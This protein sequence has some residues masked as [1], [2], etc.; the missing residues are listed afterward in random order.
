MSVVAL[1]QVDEMQ[2][3]MDTVQM[4]PKGILE[5]VKTKLCEIHC[6]PDMESAVPTQL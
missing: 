2:L 3:G 1:L 4:Q 6:N 5:V